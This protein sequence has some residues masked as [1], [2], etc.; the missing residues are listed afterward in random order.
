MGF[1]KRFISKDSIQIAANRND[2]VYFYNYFK[3]DAILSE[4]TFSMNILKKIQK[5]TI[6]DKYEIISI[7]NECK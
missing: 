2:Y 6:D 4:D 3:S 7:M 5:C 1:N